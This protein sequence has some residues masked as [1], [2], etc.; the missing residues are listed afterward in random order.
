M[1]VLISTSIAPMKYH[2][3]KATWG[4]EG[5]FHVILPHCCSSKEVRTGT[6]GRYLE[7][8]ANAEAI[9]LFMGLHLMAFSGCFI[10]EPR[11]TSPGMA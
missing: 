7:A 11:T 2:D 3:Q 4:E 1:V 5:F 6:Q 10:I 9:L 8:G